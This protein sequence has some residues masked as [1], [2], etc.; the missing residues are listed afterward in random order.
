MFRNVPKSSH[1]GGEMAIVERWAIGRLLAGYRYWS[2]IGYRRWWVGS[3]AGDR[4]WSE[5]L[6]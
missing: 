2:G 1:L 5:K 4:R 6:G 3:G